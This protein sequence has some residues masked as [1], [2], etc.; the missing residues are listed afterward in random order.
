MISFHNRIV[1]TSSVKSELLRERLPWIDE[2]ISMRNRLNW[3]QQ[4]LAGKTGVPRGTIGRMEKGE[5]YPSHDKVVNILD[6]LY[7]HLDVTKKPMYKICARKIIS[8]STKATLDEA[9]E[10]LMNKKFDSIPIIDGKILRGKITIFRLL[11]RRERKSNDKVSIILD[12]APP[13][14]PYN[15]PI[16]SVESLLKTPGDCIL[17][18]KSGELFGIVT[19]WDIRNPKLESK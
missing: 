1:I 12:E 6:V 7:R 13:T 16:K 18:T 14:V 8:L 10:L 11:S 19:A 3:S 15:T 9:A 4:K 2:I 17:L 5:Y